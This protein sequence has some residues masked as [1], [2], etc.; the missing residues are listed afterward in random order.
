MPEDNGNSGAIRVLLADHEGYLDSLRTLIDR[1]PEL[2]V[3]ATATDGL[4][5]IELAGDAAPELHRAVREA[6]A[7]EVMLKGEIVDSLV[8]R[9]AAARLES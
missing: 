8:A 4:A 2:A 3:V 6:G 9:L 1:Q 7:D 5:A